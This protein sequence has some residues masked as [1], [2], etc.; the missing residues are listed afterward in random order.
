MIYRPAKPSRL[1]DTWLFE[2]SGQ[3][4]L[5]FLE[6]IKSTWDHVG[7]AI[8]NDLVHWETCPSIP[9]KGKPGQWNSEVALTGM[10]VPHQDKFYMFVGSVFNKSQVIG[11]Y[12]SDDLY[13]WKHYYGNPVM[14]PQGPHYITEASPAFGDSVDWRDPCI[15]Y[16][17]EDKHY[18][19]L[20]CAR[21]PKVSH[22]NTGAVIAHLKSKD[23][24]NWEYLPPIEADLSKFYHAEVPDIFK[25]NNKYYLLFS[26]F[27]AGGI[28]LNTPSR[29]RAAGS[30]YMISDNIDG[31]FVLPEDY[32]LIGA[33]LSKMGP[34]VGRTIPYD[35]GRLLY[36]HIQNPTE[37]GPAFCSPKMI[38]V[39]IDD[40][41]FLKYMPVLEKLETENIYESIDDIKLPKCKDMGL[42]QCHQG[43]ICGTAEAWGTSCTI[44]ESLSDVHIK[45]KLK[46]DAART[47]L[48][49]RS[50]ASKGVLVALDFINQ[51]L[52]IGCMRYNKTTGWGPDI[53]A[54][55]NH[56]NYEP[57]D[58]CKKKL[59]KNINYE[60]RCFVRS[61][62]FEVYLNDEWVFTVALNES[63]ES[64]DIEL[65]VEH[66][67]TEFSDLTLA[68]IE[69][70][71]N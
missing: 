37:T 47:G 19:A 50:K 21:R 44:A 1:W 56:K 9:T 40:S 31:P 71:A 8:S 54:V 41:L 13:N 55:V 14:S 2:W 45:F 66:G 15:S 46:S 59:N 64:G 57:W 28:K 68:L 69:P 25:L 26:T 42:W 43:K 4:H 62:F 67:K 17:Q 23:L 39:K 61:E 29:K 51:Q 3:F 12:I 35:N 33:G 53:D 60:L 34:Y 24:L 27:S 58:I 63:P 22:D 20:L 32:L 16:R 30:F 18:H 70:M 7:H 11:V 6:T 52:E 36:H 49:L 65:F 5:F 48:A 10:V 38:Q